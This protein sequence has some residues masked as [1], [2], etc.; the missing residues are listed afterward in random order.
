[1]SGW[2]LSF[3]LKPCS[4]LAFKAPSGNCPIPAPLIFRVPSL[5]KHHLSGGTYPARC[6]VSALSHAHSQAV[7]I[8]TLGP[9]NQA[10]NAQEGLERSGSPILFHS[11]HG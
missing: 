1:M 6:V 10:G 5:R 11:Q 9:V 8:G 2:A 4:V 7:Q 3:S